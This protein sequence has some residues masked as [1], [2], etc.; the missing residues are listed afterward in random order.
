[1]ASPASLGD[2]GYQVAAVFPL[3]TSSGSYY[4]KTSGTDTGT[5]TTT[6]RTIDLIKALH[7]TGLTTGAKPLDVTVHPRSGPPKFSGIGISVP[8][9][10]NFHSSGLQVLI[11]AA[12]KTR[13]AT[14]GAGSTWATIKSET[15]RFKMGTDTDAVAHKGFVSSVGVQSLQRYYKVNFT[16]RFR[17]ASSTAGKD[18]TTGQ[19][20]FVIHQPSVILWAPGTAPQVS[21]PA[22]S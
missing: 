4:V 13:A 6:S 7:E 5:V 18:T 1:M 9:K 2:F 14:S 21:V 20:G 19:G 8:L 10:M 22:R 11:T 3:A 16:I 15:L 12:Q 17:L